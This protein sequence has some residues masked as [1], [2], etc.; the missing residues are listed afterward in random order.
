MSVRRAEAQLVQGPLPAA[1]SDKGH[2]LVSRLSG[3]DGWGAEGIIKG[4]RGSLS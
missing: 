3:A 1:P 4:F 2:L